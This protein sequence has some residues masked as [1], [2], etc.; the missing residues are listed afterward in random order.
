MSAEPGGSLVL[1]GT[2]IGNREDLSPRAVRAM[3]EADLLFC[4]DTRSPLR[5]VEAGTELPPRIS[6]FVGNEHERLEQLRA[7]LLDGKRVAFV[8][9]AGMPVWSDPGRQLVELA[10]EVGATV[11]VVPGPTA[12]ATALAASGFVAEGAVFVG[13]APRAGVEREQALERAS[14][15]TG[16]CMFY[17]AGNR[18]AAL[19]RDLASLE[20]EGSTRRVLVARELTKRHQELRRG[21]LGVVAAELDGSLRGE[22]CIVLEGRPEVA[23]AEGDPAEQRAREVLELMLDSTLKPRARAKAIAERTGLDARELYARLSAKRGD[24]T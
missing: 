4:E 10:W 2:P 20:A 5:L 18:S 24:D 16:A 9:E 8:S 21:P 3:L 15:S 19:L 11:D 23:S 17:E 22:V 1:V 12:A 6:C 7:A 13:F 14:K